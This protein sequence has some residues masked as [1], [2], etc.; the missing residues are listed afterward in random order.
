MN[1]VPIDSSEDNLRSLFKQIGGARVERVEFEDDD[2]PIGHGMLVKGEKWGEEA[3]KGKK[4]KRR[5]EGDREIGEVHRLPDVWATKI[6]KSGSSAVVVFV[7]RATRDAVVKECGRLAKKKEAV[8]WRGSTEDLG[9]KRYQQHHALNYPDRAT[10]Q[11]SVN[12]YLAAYATAEA[13][14]ASKLK[15]LRSEP[16]ED[17]FVTV[18]RGGRSGPARMEAAQATQERHKEREKKRAVKTF[19]RFQSREMAKE[20]ERELRRKFEEDVQKVED[21]RRRK[22]GRIRPEE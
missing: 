15:Q 17:G 20:K 5:H 9:L 10:L 18:T 21:V 3:A 4:R 12:G 8:E 7:D 13:E 1:N 2:E 19:Y 14:R 16:D 11:A 22:G 6:H